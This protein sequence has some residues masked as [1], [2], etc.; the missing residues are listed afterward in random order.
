MTLEKNLVVHSLFEF[1]FGITSV[2]STPSVF[3]PL[4]WDLP[5]ICHLGMRRGKSMM[6]ETFSY[7]MNYIVALCLELNMS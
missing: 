3:S 7:E 6:F 2:G 4:T 1:C 5:Y